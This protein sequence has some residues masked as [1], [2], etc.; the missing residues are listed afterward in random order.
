M[1]F[2]LFCITLSGISTTYAQK[3]IVEL[4]DTSSK[5]KMLNNLKEKN[6]VTEVMKNPTVNLFPNPAKNKVELQIKGFQPGDIRIQL[7]NKEGYI[8]RDDTRT[9][10][11]GNE[12]IIMMFAEK[13]G[14]YFLLLKQGNR[15]I[16][17][18]LLIQ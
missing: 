13:P 5:M 8:V 10:L 4:T 16:K 11:I 1:K 2:I 17:T 14:L 3:Q 9:V 12:P 6:A 15:E 18:K 7:I